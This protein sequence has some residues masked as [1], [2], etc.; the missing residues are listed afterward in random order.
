MPDTGEIKGKDKRADGSM[1]FKCIGGP[2]HDVFVRVPYPYDTLRF[3]GNDGVEVVYEL[4]APLK[5][6]RSKQHVF[7]HNDTPERTQ[8]YPT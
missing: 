8:E 5:S 2:L 4:T 7:I 1:R 3:P 6:A